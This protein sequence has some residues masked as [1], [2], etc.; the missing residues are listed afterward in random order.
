MGLGATSFG[1]AA[2]AMAGP[3]LAMQE[4]AALRRALAAAV[5]GAETVPPGLVLAAL[6]RVALL[7]SGPA[8]AACGGALLAGLVQ[9]GGLF[10]PD[11]LTPRLDRIDPGQGLRRLLSPEGAGQAIF[12]TLAIVATVAVGAWHLLDR[13]PVLSQVPRMRVGAALGVAGGAI[14]RC[15]RRWPGCSRERGSSTSCCAGAAT[16]GSCA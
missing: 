8:A 5:S 15:C 2:L 7:W 16:S 11:T 12:A 4:A 13:A 1:L 10:A 3:S 9:T 6:G 14:G